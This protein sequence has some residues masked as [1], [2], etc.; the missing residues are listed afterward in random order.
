MWLIVAGHAQY[1]CTECSACFRTPNPLKCHIMHH[2]VASLR[3]ASPPLVDRTYSSGWH[4]VLLPFLL[5]PPPSSS[6]NYFRFVTES[7][8]KADRWRVLHD[9]NNFQGRTKPRQGHDWSFPLPPATNH[10]RFEAESPTREQG[11]PIQVRGKRRNGC[12]RPVCLEE[13]HSSKAGVGSGQSLTHKT[14][15][16]GFPESTRRTPFDLE[17]T[18]TRTHEISAD[19]KRPS[20]ATETGTGSTSTAA[21]REARH[22]CAFCGKRYSRRYGLTIHV[23]T[24]T[25]HKPLQCAICRRPFG[26]PSN[27]NKHVR[28]HA[29]DADTPYRCRHCGK[30]L[31]R[32]RDLERHVRSRHPN[33]GINTPS[34][35]LSA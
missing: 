28:L 15:Q 7:P 8:T 32:R 25:G 33:A 17:A 1:V 21:V 18:T 22:E 24:H 31:V 13:D 29:G 11:E 3:H 16:C 6:P 10:I 34:P 14:A 35:S 4:S 2:C 12:W 23:R 20:L 27:L 9:A 26:D 19:R 30:V 5:A